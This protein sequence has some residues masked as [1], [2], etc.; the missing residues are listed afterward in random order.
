MRPLAVVETQILADR[1]AGLRDAG[2]GSEVDLLVF[3][4]PPEPLDEDV[5]TPCA[6]AVHADSD[7]GG[8][9]HLGEVGR[10]ELTSLIGVED[11]RLAMPRERLLQGLDAEVRR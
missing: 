11:L 10:A 1:S 7:F 4:R 9:Q 8:L 6:L 2:V 5:V 3:D